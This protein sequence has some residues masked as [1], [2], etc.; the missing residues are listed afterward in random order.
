[1]DTKLTLLPER[2]LLLPDYNTLVVADWHLGKGTHFRKAGIFIPP[3]SVDKD[4]LRLQSVLD[5]FAI[6]TAVFL[7]D[8][9]H[10]DLN[11]EWLAFERFRAANRS[12]RLVLTRG[13]HDILPDELMRTA[14]VEVVDHYTAAPR[15]YCT[16]HPQSNS[17]IGWLNIAGHVHP[18]C[19]VTNAGRQRYRLPCFYHHGQTLL[20]PAFGTL[21]GLH[22][23]PH[24]SAARIFPVV[25]DR[26]GEL[27]KG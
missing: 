5:R 12:I 27:K 1:M 18:G 21:T 24:R 16:H 6:H 25:G 3:A 23:M 2:A 19:L 22:L 13:N 15:I 14:T 9:F 7:G 8:L 20:L 17:P 10:S 4:V 26:V 11:S